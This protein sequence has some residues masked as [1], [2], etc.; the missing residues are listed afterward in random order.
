MGFGRLSERNGCF[1]RPSVQASSKRPHFLKSRA[2]SW[3]RECQHFV[4]RA[5]PALSANKYGIRLRRGGYGATGPP[6]SSCRRSERRQ[7]KE[8][9]KWGRK[10][11]RF[12]YFY[13]HLFAFSGAL[14]CFAG[15]R[16]PELSAAQ[17]PRSIPQSKFV[18][19]RRFAHRRLTSLRLNHFQK[20][21]KV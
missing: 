5:G 3:L 20:K 12:L 16:N 10:N 21:V 7:K 14:V 2:F 19:R 4:F 1:S 9:K 6:P 13:P 11:V 8:A 15:C 17:Q 18:Y